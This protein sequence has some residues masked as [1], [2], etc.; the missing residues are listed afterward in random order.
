VESKQVKNPN[1]PEYT[2][3]G[4]KWY[5]PFGYMAQGNNKFGYLLGG[6][7]QRKA[8]ENAIPEQS[9]KGLW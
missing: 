3:V 2:P 7:W 6:G 1:A 5:N 8:W 9:S 4:T